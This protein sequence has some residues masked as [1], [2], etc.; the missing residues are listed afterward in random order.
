MISSIHYLLI[1]V[2]YLI[3]YVFYVFYY[4]YSNGDNNN[5]GDN[6]SNSHSLI[7]LNFY[8]LIHL[9]VI[10]GISLLIAIILRGKYLIFHTY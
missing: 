3:H 2:W 1:C 10:S 8:K 4:N 7:M 6:N 9:Y 5:D